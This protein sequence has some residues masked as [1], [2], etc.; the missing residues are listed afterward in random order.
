ML[1]IAL[2]LG[3]SFL[4]G[5]ADYLGGVKSRVFPVAVVLAT[6]YL[7]SLAVMALFVG[8]RG[9]GPPGTEAIVAGMGAGLFGVG[10]LMAFYR[11]LAIGTMSIVA[12]V[13]STGVALP[14]L[15]GLAIGDQPGLLRSIGL[16]AAVVGVVLASREDDKAAA[17]S[18]DPRLQRQSILLAIVA[19]LGFGMYF[20]LAEIS[21]NGDVGWALLLS[22]IAASPFIVAFAVITLRRGGRRPSPLTLLAIVAIGLLDLAANVL[23]NTATTV[24]E[25][26]TVAVASSLYPVTTVLLAAA[27]LGERVRGTQRIGVVVALCGVV[28]ISAGA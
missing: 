17:G 22:R 25:L 1:A 16:A 14:V 28:L 11:A 5:L 8:V 24:G 26:S 12:P 3:S 21:S 9:E 7:A 23:Y 15:V 18:V 2:G 4:W 13:A 27:L 20:V 19:G 6:M 10:A